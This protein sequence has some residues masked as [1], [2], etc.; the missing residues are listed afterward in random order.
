MGA[1]ERAA[2][3]TT[4]FRFVVTWAEALLPSSIP[5]KLAQSGVSKWVELDGQM[6]VVVLV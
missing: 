2:H 5:G 4:R 1:A 3:V 6:E